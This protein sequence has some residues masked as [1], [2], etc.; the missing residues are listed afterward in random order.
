MTAPKE[1]GLICRGPE[2]LAIW[3]GR[4][5]QVRRYIKP[6]RR[7][8]WLTPG[9]LLSVKRWANSLGTDW[10][11]MAVGEESRIVHCG[12]E[13][14]G[15]HIGSVRCP[16]GKVGDLIFVKEPHGFLSGAGKRIV[17]A[18]D[19]IPK[20]RFS[21]EEIHGMKWRPATHM[22]REHARSVR[23]I[24]EIRIERLTDI[25]EADAVAN[26]IRVQIGNGSGPGAGYK[27]SGPGYTGIDRKPSPTFHVADSESGVCSCF[28]RP[29][30]KPAACAYREFW[31]S[32]NGPGSWG[33]HWVWVLTL[34]A[35]PS[36]GK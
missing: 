22:T 2:A 30:L 23:Q 28:D 15:G 33:Q 34:T 24:T 13:M 20:D 7:Q 4:Q 18:A 16:F 5:R 32:L 3:Q 31:E 8:D 1:R 9:A 25:S 11:T 6:G 35:A 17:Y 29:Q 19:G 12:H 26:G 36:E 10:W 27:W 21:G 14:D